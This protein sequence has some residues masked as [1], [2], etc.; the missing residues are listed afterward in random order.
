MNNWQEVLPGFWLPNSWPWTEEEFPDYTAPD[1]VRALTDTPDI[2]SVIHVRDWGRP[3][4]KAWGAWFGAFKADKLIKRESEFFRPI[5][6]AMYET[7]RYKFL[8][9][10]WRRALVEVLTDLDNMEDQL[11]TILWVAEIVTRKFIPIPKGL[12]DPVKKITN[13]LDCAGKLVAGITPF[14]GSKS[15][16]TE[17]LE[18]LGREKKRAR[19]QKAGLIAWFQDN[20]GRLIEAAQATDE[21]FDVGLVLG[22][23]FA[24]IDEGLWGLTKQTAGNYL[25]ATDALFPGYAQWAKETDQQISEAITE[26]WDSTWGAID[27]DTASIEEAGL[28]N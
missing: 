4:T 21:W 28:L 23:V 5:A 10:A 18:E 11:S 14:R 25:L 22:P 7:A 27:W 15:R 16:Y 12:L 20:W 1:Y 26:A 19:E 13:T 9:P 17:C 2:A 24:Y 3:S 6:N 8:V